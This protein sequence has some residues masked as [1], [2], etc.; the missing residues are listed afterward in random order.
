MTM[1]AS[2]KRELRA[3]VAPRYRDADRAEKTRILNEFVEN[4][5]Y[6]RKYA[7]RVL[8][9]SYVP[10]APAGTRSRRYGPDVEDA[11]IA[12]WTAAHGVCAKRLVPFLPD[13]VAALERHGHLSLAEETRA[14]LLGI[15]AAT[16]D[17]ILTRLHPGDKPRGISTSR[18]GTL[19]RHQVPVRTFADW[20]DAKPGFMEAD[21]VAHCGTSAAG[22]FL[23]TL[24]LTD[25]AT[26]WTECI[27]LLHRSGEEVL[28]GIEWARG[29]LPFPL[30][31]L[32]TDNGG[33]FLNQDFLEYCDTEHIKYT[34]GRAY[35]KND[36][37]F[38]EQKNGVIVRQWVGYGR[39]L[40]LEAFRRLGE[41]YP[42]VRLYVN[43]FQPSMKLSSKQR[44][45]S[46]VTK[47]YLPA[48]TPYRRLRATGVLSEPDC[49]RLE[50]CYAA[51]DPVTLLA[52][53]AAHQEAFWCHEVGASPPSSR[54][55]APAKAGVPGALIPPPVAAP[56]SVAPVTPPVAAPVPGPHR[57]YRPARRHHLFAEVWD[58]VCRWLAAAPERSAKS[59]FAELEKE[60]PGEFQPGQLRTLQR[61][62]RGW[63]A[64]MVVR[65]TTP[66]PAAARSVG[67]ADE[68]QLPHPTEQDHGE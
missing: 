18:P 14:R 48:L 36:Q 40:G 65:Y 23:N 12:V 61:R 67:K 3:E 63:R 57:R 5:G 37:C 15:S 59:L 4:T 50:A 60:H 30:L 17:R 20:D 51:L 43:F 24:V 54:R 41:L 22:S 32:D 21:L 52:Q 64:E 42:V 35:R 66:R 62:V 2:G 58:E 19:L 28:R 1:S 44:E 45:G 55:G 16:V 10:R 25:V 68:L 7:I 39:Y 33:E 46:K 47:R 49:E 11:L 56:T 9:H 53:L 34:R 27:P 29:L 8:T 13:L 31:G 6:A 26:A 38:V